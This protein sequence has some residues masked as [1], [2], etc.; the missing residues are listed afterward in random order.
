MAY[1]DALLDSVV[2]LSRAA[3]RA[4]EA[5]EGAHAF[6]VP[7]AMLFREGP[8][9]HAVLRMVLK[10]G[11]LCVVAGVVHCASWEATKKAVEDWTGKPCTLDEPG[12]P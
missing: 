1:Q 5:L 12:P 7:Y 2:A 4:E 9:Q 3:R 11:H 8:H 10:P 6:P